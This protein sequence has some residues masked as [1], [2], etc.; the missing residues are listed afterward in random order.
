MGDDYPRRIPG[1]HGDSR[2]SESHVQFILDLLPAGG[3][4]LEVGSASG[5]TAAFIAD[6]RPTGRV[7]CVDTY[8]QLETYTEILLRLMDWRRNQRPNMGLWVGDI[9]SMVASLGPTTRFDVAFVDADHAYGPT[10]DVLLRMPPLMAESGSIIVHDWHD[11]HWPAVEPAVR[12]F[13]RQTPGWHLS[14]E[15]ASICSISRRE[16]EG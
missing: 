1:Y 6:S 13:L 7:V 3:M 12:E 9:A 15:A 5:T 11:K 8:V 10:L 4:F 16:A 14:G 2:I